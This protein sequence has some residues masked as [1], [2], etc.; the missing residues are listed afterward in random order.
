M[1]K[2]G[3]SG[4]RGIIADTFT[5]ANVQKVAYALAMILKKK[6]Q[7]KSIVAIGFDNRFMGREFAQSFCEVL[8]AYGIKSKFFEK[9]TSCTIIAYETINNCFGVHITASHNPFFYNG[10]KVFASMGRETTSE[11]NN[12]FADIANAV[13]IKDIKVL[14]FAD[15]I[16]K[17]LVEITTDILPYCNALLKL[18]DSTKIKKLKL[19]ILFN[20]MGGSAVESAEIVLKKLNLDY[21]IMNKEIN[22]N[23]NNG[24]PAPY[25]QNL[26]NQAKRVKKEKFNL[27]IAVDG[28]GDRVSFLDENGEFYDCNY[29]SAL[30]YN[31]LLKKQKGDFVKNCALTELTTKIA[32]RNGQK[33]INAEVGFKNV[34]QKM[35][36][37]KNAIIGAESNGIALKNFI[38]HKDGLATSALLI[39]V[40]VNSNKPLSRLIA[41]L[42]QEYNFPCETREYAYPHTDLQRS[43]IKDKIF[44]QKS[45]PNFPQEIIKTDYSDGLKV[46]F[47]NNYWCVIR[48]S[49]TENVIR[50]F[51]EMKDIKTCEKYIK[52][53]EDFIGL[54]IRQ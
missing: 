7:T 14:T 43:E 16:K 31:Y 40:L 21:E 38:Y 51:A 36:E 4:F 37:N 9:S 45:L 34:A 39:E 27:G 15:A 24:L 18:V 42:K 8:S 49:G 33:T 22:P 47:K 20:A 41:E 30:I 1:I 53:M 54:N 6:K 35:L 32:E 52:V 13:E 44:V 19:K 5:K 12:E 50:L 2:F 25:K 11:Q 29:I 17:G 48:L 23:F 3:T 26:T 10:I 46:Y 28:D